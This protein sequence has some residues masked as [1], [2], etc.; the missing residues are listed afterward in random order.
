MVFSATTLV[1]VRTIIKVKA[2]DTTIDAELTGLIAAVSLRAE[3]YIGRSFEQTERTETYDIGP[4]TRAVFLENWPI[5]TG[6]TF[7]VRNHVT[8]DFTITAMTDTLYAID[9]DTGRVYFTS[10]LI[11]GPGVMQIKY[12]GGLA[13]SAVNLQAIEDLEF[14]IRR[15]V[16]Y[17]YM[18]RNTPG[19]S[20]PA[21]GRGKGTGAQAEGEVN[22][23]ISTQD[24]LDS[25]KSVWAR[26]GGLGK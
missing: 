1:N 6:Q 8:R 26:A 15:Q 12:T 21:F 11:T 22:W 14:A 4:R 7:E 25:Y 13:T 2:G 20:P 23:L 9:A 24:V 10:Y 18:R 16:G 3:R 19:G 17:E 5:D